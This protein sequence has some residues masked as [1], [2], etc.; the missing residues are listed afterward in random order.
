MAE[1]NTA[2]S[3]TGCALVAIDDSE[4]S[5]WAFNCK[6]RRQICILPNVYNFSINFSI[7]DRNKDDKYGFCIAYIYFSRTESASTD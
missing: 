2:P 3:S 5:L 4:Q 6:Y 7:N 1:G